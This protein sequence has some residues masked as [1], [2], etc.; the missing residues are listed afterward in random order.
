[1][2]ISLTALGRPKALLVLAGIALSLSF[3]SRIYWPASH[4]LDIAG[5]PIGRDF[6]NN[7]AGPQIAFRGHVMTLYDL[8]AYPKAI[9]RLFGHTLPFHNW[10]YPPFSLLLYWPLG[11]APYFVA[12]GTWTIGLFA[13]YAFVASRFV[14]P[15][16]RL[17][18]VLALVCAPAC[19]VNV[20]GGQNG[21][22]TATL[23]LGAIL[24]LDRRPILAGMLIGLLTL[25]PQLGLVLPLALL[26]LRAWRTIAS[27]LVTIIVLVAVS[28]AAFG[29]EPWRRYLFETSAYQLEL[30]K[31]F[32][33][34]YTYMMCSVL[35]G[36]RTLGVPFPVAALVQTFVAL[37]VVLLSGLAVRWTADARQRA[38]ILATAAPLVTP[39][40]F[41][42]DLTLVTVVVAWRL[43]EDNWA[44]RLGRTTPYVFAWLTP[45]LLMPLNMRSIPIAP[46][47]LLA[48]FACTIAD[49][50]GPGGVSARLR[51]Q[52]LI[53][54]AKALFVR[55]VPNA[56]RREEMDCLLAEDHR[57]ID[58]LLQE[59]YSAKDRGDSAP[60]EPL[61]VLLAEERTRFNA[62]R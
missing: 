23:F 41:N 16:N 43:I 9:S 61:H 56:C 3:L 40:A 47:A 2:K 18:M 21:F 54:P 17:A 35:S 12:L 19:L 22:L 28:M 37:P 42:Y 10:S 52:R 24:A 50:A 33:G 32:H 58:P 59:A 15:A 8:E 13:A 55:W 44:N 48:L 53:A 6:I 29:L 26:S 62:S 25:K 46:L 30:L 7:W 1:M 51:P 57:E 27:T 5:Y 60:L 39:Y 11:Q 45:V 14:A 38:M 49:V 36:A 31:Q 34:F 20:V 4:G